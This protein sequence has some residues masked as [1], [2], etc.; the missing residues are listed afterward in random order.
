MSIY[1]LIS[2]AIHLSKQ[3]IRFA[4]GTQFSL[5]IH[6]TFLMRHIFFFIESAFQKTVSP[7]TTT[8]E[9]E[10]RK[11]ICKAFWNKWTQ[12]FSWYFEHISSKA[13]TF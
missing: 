8:E 3:T 2:V 10:R 13:S 11:E 6:P 5:F 9:R 4:L 1:T 7:E 12:R